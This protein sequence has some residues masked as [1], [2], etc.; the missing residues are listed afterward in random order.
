[1]RIGSCSVRMGGI[2]G[3]GTHPDH[4]RAGYASAMMK[5]AIEYMHSAGYAISVLFSARA[6]PLYRSLGYECVPMEGVRIVPR[7]TVDPVKTDWQVEPF[8]EE[9]DL[10]QVATLY[11]VYNAKQSGSI[12]RSRAHWDT[13]TARLRGTLPALV[14]RHDDTLGGYLSCVVAGSA[15]RVD[16]VAYDR[17]DPSALVALTHHLLRF[18]E[19]KQIK[20]IY[21]KIPTPSP[22]DRPAHGRL[23]RR[24]LSDWRLNDDALCRQSPAVPSQTLA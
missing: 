5:D 21:G 12:V 15:M 2:G 20:E 9:R 17:A 23:R 3:V 8:D 1:M 11:N 7:R 4:R 16:E 6:Q 19:E 22:L 13:T 14:A 18:C 10:E 24:S